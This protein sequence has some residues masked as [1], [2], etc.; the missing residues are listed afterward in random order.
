MQSRDNWID[1]LMHGR[2][3]DD[4]SYFHSWNLPAEKAKAFIELLLA[5]FNEGYPYFQVRAL[6]HQNYRDELQR[7]LEESDEKKE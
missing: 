7:R 3:H 6:G 5:Y 1:F 2:F 4:P